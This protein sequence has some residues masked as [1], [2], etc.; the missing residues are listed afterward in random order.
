MLGA[1]RSGWQRARRRLTHRVR[2]SDRAHVLSRKRP[3]AFQIA[4]RVY[5][6][7]DDNA[8]RGREQAVASLQRL[9]GPQLRPRLLAVVYGPPDACVLAL[10]DVVRAGAELILF[11][12]FADQ[13][14]QMECLVVEVLPRLA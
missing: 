5:I 13:A 2:R 6:V 11:M 12:P 8:E 14:E 4:K 7:V 1:G 3:A 9:F 10:R